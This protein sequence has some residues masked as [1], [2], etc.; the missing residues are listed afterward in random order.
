MRKAIVSSFILA[1]TLLSPVY[2]QT[3]EKSL[4]ERLGGYDA[5]SA[6]VNEL[7]TRKA[8]IDK[9][10]P[11]AE[12]GFKEDL[13]K[14]SQFVSL[15]KG[16]FVWHP[17]A[18]CEAVPIILEGS[19]KVYFSAENGREIFLYRI[20]RGETCVLTN[21]A[22]LRKTYYPAYAVCEEDVLGYVILA[23][24]A[25]YLFDKYSYWRNF[26]IYMMVKNVYGLF[27]V[28]NELISKRVDQRLTDYLRTMAKDGLI[29]ATHEEIA[30]DI[31]TAREVVSRLLK[32]LERE[33]Y[34]EV[35]RGKIRI[36]KPI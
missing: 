23:D 35:R 6:V 11:Y 7:A 19:V 20:E 28:L 29:R 33:G 24:R 14:C 1:G 9:L 5:I 27:L 8:E 26:V 36:V 31:G 13:V 12:N 3:K 10:F 17:G 18:V 4:Y 22:V 30:R 34:L 25:V 32:E 21:L 15:K 2:A 16:T